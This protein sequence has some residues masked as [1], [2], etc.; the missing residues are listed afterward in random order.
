MTNIRKPDIREQTFRKGISF[1]NDEELLM[2]ILGSGIKGCPVTSLARKVNSVIEESSTENL[3][4]N[5]GAIKGMGKGKVLSVAA[6]VEFGRR[7][8]CSTGVR[9][10]HPEDLIPY[11]QPYVLK[12][13]EHFLCVTL[14][15]NHEIIQVHLISVGTVDKSII[16]PREVFAVALQESAAAI[17][18]CHNHPSGNSEPSKADIA[19]TRKL[20]EASELIGV[21]VLDHIIIN[22][23]GYFSFMEHDLLFT[24]K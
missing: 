21:P 23:N 13:K 15:G 5:L 14:N 18:L 8:N 4:Q 9:I 17:I 20:L 19:T 2:L 3:I 1:P 12:K 22:V 10:C 6:A 7:K 16:Y 11:V 24:T